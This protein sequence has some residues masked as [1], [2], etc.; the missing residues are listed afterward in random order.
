[1]KTE[2]IK[3]TSDKKGISLIV[4]VITIIVI[5]ILA[6]AVILSIA[7]NNPIESA[8]EAR[9]KNDMKNIEEE[10]SLYIAK[11]Y[12][13][14][15]GASMGVSNLEGDGMVSV[16]PTTKNY[17]EKVKIKDGKLCAIKNK[18]NKEEKKWINDLKIDMPP[19]IYVLENGKYGVSIVNNVLSTNWYNSENGTSNIPEEIGTDI[20][21]PSGVKT[22][23]E[24]TF[25]GFEE[26]ETIKIPE[27]VNTIGGYAFSSCEK[28][29]SV[30]LPEGITVLDE[31]VFNYCSMLEEVVIPESVTQIRNFAFYRCSSLKKLEIP[32]NVSS[33]AMNA[34]AY[35]SSIEELTFSCTAASNIKSNA[36]VGLKSLKK[37]IISANVNSIPNKTFN[38]LSSSIE[39]TIEGNARFD[40]SAIT[41]WGID[42]TKVTI[43]GSGY[44]TT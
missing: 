22:I 37:L 10:L 40:N 9:F 29:K 28:L 23:S 14:S 15:Q 12:A 41:N 19:D 26:L 5:I 38:Y 7:N 36:F 34:F 25:C 27:S 33:I 18:I 21:I 6:V 20:E 8:K 11:S 35:N 30:K 43:S 24:Y 42:P 3:R 39:V 17:K 4:L 2:E 13:D 16:L 32:K 44:K 31:E 1:M